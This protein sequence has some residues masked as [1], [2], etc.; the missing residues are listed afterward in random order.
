M[1]P[2]SLWRDKAAALQIKKLHASYLKHKGASGALLKRRTK[3]A[4]KTT[5]FLSR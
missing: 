2:F 1:V 5:T 3:N 4:Q